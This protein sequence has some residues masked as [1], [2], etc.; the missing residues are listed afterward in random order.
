MATKLLSEIDFTHHLQGVK[1]HA[2]SG[3]TPVYITG[4]VEAKDFLHFSSVESLTT[5]GGGGT[6]HYLDFTKLRTWVENMYEDQELSDAIA[7]EIEKG[8]CYADTI[9][10]IKQLLEERI[11]QCQSL[12]QNQKVGQ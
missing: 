2:M 3:G 6:I 12:V 8:S 4:L 9:G 11:K 10:P 1:Y 7:E 5:L